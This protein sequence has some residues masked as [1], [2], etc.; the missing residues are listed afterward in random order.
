M[1]LLKPSTL[2]K[3][4]TPLA[5]LA[6]ISTTLPAKQNT[7]KFREKIAR[8]KNP[9]E[10]ETG[11]SIR[12]NNIDSWLGQDYNFMRIIAAKNWGIKIEAY[13][14]ERYAKEEHYWLPNGEFL[15]IGNSQQN[16]FKTSLSGVKKCDA[17]ESGG[18]LITA[19]HEQPR[20]VPTAPI[21][22]T[23]WAKQEFIF[24]G[25]TEEIQNVW[26][27]ELE[28]TDNGS[29]I[30]LRTYDIEGKPTREI[31]CNPETSK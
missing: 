23:S 8:T 9:V 27:W 19:T 5:I 16:L 31:S 13:E 20:C 18:F 6:T 22:R 15:K 28:I 2:N 25:D 12:V 10:K 30:T 14:E 24:N 3:L 1:S 29:K 11:D 21:L 17:L 4:I 7:E 26:K